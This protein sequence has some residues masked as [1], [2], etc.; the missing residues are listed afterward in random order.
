MTYERGGEGG[1]GL[2]DF[3]EAMIFSPHRP[4]RQIFFQSKTVQKIWG[5]EGDYILQDFFHFNQEWEGPQHPALHSGLILCKIFI[6]VQCYA[7]TCNQY[8]IHNC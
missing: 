6:I 3:S 8:L 1:W 7:S 4:T 5:G 2:E